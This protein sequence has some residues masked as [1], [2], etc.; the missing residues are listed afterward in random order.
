MGS[1][2][3]PTNAANANPSLR[4][5]HIM[6]I[7]GRGS[8][9]RA[10]SGCAPLLCKRFSVPR[11]LHLV[12]EPR[13]RSAWNQRQRQHPAFVEFPLDPSWTGAPRPPTCVTQP[14]QWQLRAFLRPQHR[15]L[16]HAS[17]QSISG[18]WL[19]VST[20]VALETGFPFTPQLGYNPT[21]TGDTRNPV[22]P[23]WNPAFHGNLYPRTASQYFNPAAFLPP[24]TGTYGNVFGVI[25]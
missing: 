24:A 1:L 20:I 5:L 25:P 13:R 6:G 23:N 21:V 3:Y 14:H 11:Q 17:K 12:K 7:A 10:G 2:F 9:Q 22:R 15:F 18:G 8:L 19:T 4:Q 16:N